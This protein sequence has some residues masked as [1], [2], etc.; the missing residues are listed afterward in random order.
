MQMEQIGTPRPTAP[1]PPSVSP[2]PL[3]RATHPPAPRTTSAANGNVLRWLRIG[4]EAA[5]VLALAERALHRRRGERARLVATTAA[6]AGVALLDTLSAT[7][8]LRTEP[9][10]LLASVTVNSP[11]EEVYAFW[12]DFKNLPGFM[13]HL[14]E[15][16]EFDGVT[17]WRARGPAGI[18]LQ[19]DA[20][21]VAD[22]ANERISWRS[23][24]GAEV[25]NYGSVTFLPGPRGRGTEVHVA[26]GFEPPFL[27]MSA[28]IVKLLGPIP[29]QQLLADLR[30][31]K[32][33]LETGGV[34][35]S[36]A[37]IHRGRHPARPPEPRELP[38]V[39]GLV[40]A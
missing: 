16:D 39:K 7:Q 31:F 33:M 30:R 24:E 5:A 40:R 3:K 32:Q 38:L 19:W 26:L 27:S 23:L 8:R 28:A 21:I 2:R 4:L 6:L 36:D 14:E 15:V 12:R 11:P 22:R 25:Q 29:Q 37:S 34:A 9:V 13:R 18:P 35:T 20:A 17:I 1:Q 10:R